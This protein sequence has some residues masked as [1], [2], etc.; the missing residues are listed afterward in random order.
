MKRLDLAEVVLTLKASGV[1][2]VK[3]FRWLEPP[4]PKALERAEMLLED[5]GATDHKSQIT[6][7]GRRM[8]AF[9]LHPRYS[10]M[11]VEAAR[12]GCLPDAALCAALVSGR[13][14]MVR[15]GRDDAHAQEAREELEVSQQSDFFT[16]LRAYAFA[17]E[18]GFNVE[19]C[20]RRGVQ[21]QVARQIDQTLEQ[22]L[23]LARTLTSSPTTANG[24]PPTPI[25]IG[26]V[27]AS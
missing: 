21:A 24:W 10:R 18:T 2:D 9:P 6:D 22:I 1:N 13:D 23:Q 12:L 17:R 14:L 27:N 4:D 7:L 20:R 16:L 11:L 19:S 26:W 8:L 15:A 3:K 5:L 25:R